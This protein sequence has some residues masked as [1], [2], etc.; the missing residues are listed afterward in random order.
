M[1]KIIN[2][3]DLLSGVQHLQ[4][5]QLITATDLSKKDKP[6][7]DKW[8]KRGI[9]LALVINL[10]VIVLFLIPNIIK[11]LDFT[12][13]ISTHSAPC[14]DLSNMYGIWYGKTYGDAPTSVQEIYRIKNCETSPSNVLSCDQMKVLYNVK[15]G[16]DLGFMP[17]SIQ[18]DWIIQQCDLKSYQDYRVSEQQ[19]EI[20][21]ESLNSI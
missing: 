8:W 6:N 13:Y 18:R 17:G 7:G 19:A 1:T 16:Q 5:G 12:K 10:V 15:P 3:T 14:Q 4:K 21:D 9:S 20:R 2:P 11:I